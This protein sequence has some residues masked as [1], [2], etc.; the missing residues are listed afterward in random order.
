[1]Q[2]KLLNSLMYMCTDIEKL[3]ICEELFLFIVCSLYLYL[4]D[5]HQMC[6]V[7]TRIGV[8]SGE[9][10]FLYCT[11]L[12]STAVVKFTSQ[13]QRP[14]ELLFL[15]VFFYHIKMLNQTNSKF[16]VR[17]FFAALREITFSEIYLTFFFF[18]L[19]VSVNKS[20]VDVFN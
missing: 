9:A 13:Q 7:D 2:I 10:L 16:E 6:L 1:M 17:L 19:F 5:D 8:A 20:V 18:C 11:F 15:F 4:Q 14:A 3:T 12:P